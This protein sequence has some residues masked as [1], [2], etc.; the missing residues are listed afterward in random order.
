MSGLI[1]KEQSRFAGV[2]RGTSRLVSVPTTAIP[3]RLSAAGRKAFH[4][5]PVAVIPTLTTPYNLNPAA[6]PRAQATTVASPTNPF[7]ADRCL[8]ERISGIDPNREG[9]N[10]ALCAPISPTATNI[11]Q[12]WPCEMT[13]MAKNMM[14]ISMIFIVTIT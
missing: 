2:R 6:V 4:S 11:N 13:V 9:P 7:P 14:K 10:S 5:T 8:C 3:N 1:F 12:T